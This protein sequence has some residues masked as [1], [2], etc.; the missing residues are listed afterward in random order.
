[1]KA[2]IT[3]G[4]LIADTIVRLTRAMDDAR[5]KDVEALYRLVDNQ[6]EALQFFVPSG[7]KV[8]GKALR[9]LPIKNNVLIAAIMHN[10][11]HLFPSGNDK[12]HIGDIIIVTT[13]DH[14]LRS[15]DDILEKE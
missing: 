3:P 8:L 11:A 9:D 14:S 7:S 5:G 6:V 13:T 10:G 4:K 2:I 1:M 15:I 12:L